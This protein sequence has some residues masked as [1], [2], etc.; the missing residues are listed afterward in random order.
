MVDLP[1]KLEMCAL[2]CSEF[3]QAEA[4]WNVKVVTRDKATYPRFKETLL[5]SEDPEKQSCLASVWPHH[6][7][8]QHQ[9][10]FYQISY[11][12]TNLC[13]PLVKKI[14]KSKLSVWLVFV[15][16]GP[17]KECDSWCAGKVWR[18]SVDKYCNY[19]IDIGHYWYL[20]L[21][22]PTVRFF[23]APTIS[24]FSNWSQTDFTS[25]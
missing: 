23:Y 22:Y 20:K 5:R 1:E 2:I 11:L 19:I 9:P 17:S 21:S 15:S 16:I 24:I 4:C 13:L 3:L 7:I 10:F 25:V 14:L 18:N 6:Y 12:L 8:P